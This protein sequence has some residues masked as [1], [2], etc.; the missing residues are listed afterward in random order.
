MTRTTIIITAL[1]AASLAGGLE[2]AAQPSVEG[3]LAQIEKNNLS[4]KAASAELEAEK[5]EN[6]ETAIIEDPEFEFGYLWGNQ[7]AKR[8]DVSVS[9]AFDFATL[10]G[11]KSSLAKGLDEMSL[12]QYKA[13]RLDVLLEAKA[14][15]ID[16]IYCNSLLDELN[17]HL[18]QAQTLV[19][20]FEKRKDAGGATV[21]DLNKAKIHLTAVRGEI[22]AAEVER[23]ALLE[24]LRNLNGG[25]AIDDEGLEYS[26][27]DNLPADF[28]A[29]YNEAAQKNPV[30]G[31]VRQ[32]VTVEQKQLGI[33]K[34]SWLP[35]LTVGYMGEIATDEQFRGVTLGVSIPLWS[36]SN[37]VRQSKA[38]ATA[39]QMRQREAETS[40]YHSLQSLY[41]QA[42]ALRDNSEL[43]RASLVET[44]SRDYLLSAQA[45]GEIS[46]IDYLVET[47]EYYEALEATL[48][49]ERDYRHALAKLNAVNL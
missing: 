13:E 46:M 7:N 48:A 15:C 33:D 2:A 1:L 4:L 42:V 6:R 23:A 34:I 43:M 39:A 21:L 37:K 26:L 35:E 25:M 32:Q 24:T 44:D 9:Q 27:G 11:K 36:N 20:A 45:K 16:L 18:A 49:A 5:L 29:W 47:D 3:I 41:T 10:T 31:Y 38:R 22:S 19:N 8:H 17:V 40:F 28:E 30:L 12:M 14:A